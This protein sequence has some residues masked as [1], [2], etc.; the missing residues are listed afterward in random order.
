MNRTRPG[1][2][3]TRG[4]ALLMAVVSGVSVANLYYCQPLLSDMARSFHS[5]AAQA[6]IVA[7]CTQIGYAMGMLLFAPLGDT[8]DRRQLIV[9]MLICTA[10]A[11]VSAALSRSM[12][13]LQLA[14]LAIGTATIVPQLVVP[15]AAHL[16]SP[17][18]RGRAVGTVM[19][20]VLI[21]ILLT[22]TFSGFIGGTFGW[23]VIFWIGAVLMALLAVMVRTLLPSSQPGMSARYHELLSSL[24]SLI[25]EQPQLRAA[26]LTGSLLFLAFSAFWTTLV[27]QLGRAPLH[28]G[29]KVAGMFGLVGAASASAAPIVGRVADRRGPRHTLGIALL[30]AA[31][32]F[33]ALYA[34]GSH[35]WGLAI[36]VVLLDVGVQ[37]G[38]VSNQTRI[39]ALKPE[40]QNRLNTI[41]MVTYFF[42]GSLG[43]LLGV[44]AWHR[45]QWSGVCLVGF[46][47][48]I[49]ALAYHSFVAE[50]A[51]IGNELASASAR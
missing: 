36:G 31:S 32:S 47:A 23:R 51:H 35:L 14:S 45:W 39:F 46:A 43:S 42:G 12:L 1:A 16:A 41:Y 21:G 5:T 6:G 10:V 33:V 38:H 27:F 25:R 7:T 24:P 34:T 29:S 28:Y 50:K 9:T 37:A 20:G 26:M 30:L 19:S 48:L 40:A 49:V 17:G 15:F 11:L 4:T 8:R 13:W 3:L 44:F 2:A 22:R 18:E